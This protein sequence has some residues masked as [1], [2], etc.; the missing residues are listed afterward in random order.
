[1]AMMNTLLRVCLLARV[2]ARWTPIVIHG[3]A[4][5]DCDAYRRGEQPT[6]VIC[7]A[8]R[9]KAA[10]APLADCRTAC[11]AD[12]PC[13]GMQWQGEEEHKFSVSAPGQCFLLHHT[14]METE[15]YDTP[16]AKTFCMET[17]AYTR[18]P[19]PKSSAYAAIS[20]VMSLNG[21]V[22]AMVGSATKHAANPILVQDKP[23]EP[24]L[25][26]GYPN[27]VP[28]SA[29]NSAWQMWYGDCAVGCDVQVGR[30]PTLT[31]QKRAAAP[32]PS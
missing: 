11:E 1:M 26:N 19:T 25:D 31:P 22:Q 17:E 27:L 3:R 9:V 5:S 23:W 18:A 6:H 12:L 30:A 16:I 8:S 20:V 4:L 24:R 10:D 7:K 14:C 29:D 15:T 32:A 2:N 28:P 13:S 21:S